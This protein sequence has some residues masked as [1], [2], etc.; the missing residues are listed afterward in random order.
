MNVATNVPSSRGAAALAVAA[1]LALAG[2]AAYTGADKRI[3]DTKAKTEAEKTTL[4]TE[5][6]KNVELQDKQTQIDRENE[7]VGKRIAE[8]EKERVKLAASLDEALK[9]RKV[10]TARHAELKRELDSIQAETQSL[11]L[12]HKGDAVGKPDPA[13]QAAKEKRLK[14]LEERKKSLETT[15]QQLGKS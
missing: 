14:Q 2:C 12:Q 4:A 3:R 15:L 13:A 10:T 6:A 9:A 7:R 5:K 11:D 1:S 8:V